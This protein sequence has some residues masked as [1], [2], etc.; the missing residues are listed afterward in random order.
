MRFSGWSSRSIWASSVAAALVFAAPAGAHLSVNPDQVHT[1][2][3]VDLVFSVPNAADPAGLDQV[4]IE[5]PADFV[6]DDGEAIAGWT[7]SRTGQTLSWK[8]GSIPLRQYAR[9]GIRGTAP[10]EPGTVPFTVRVADRAGTSTTYRI[11]LQAVGHGPRDNGA[12]S[13]GEAALIVAVVGAGLALAALFAL[14]YVWLR[15][16]PA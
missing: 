13:L 6:L 5:V 11:A 15:P 1:G 8:G 12:R 7:Q 10:A 4:T 2:A 3:L 16:P 14:L 9:F